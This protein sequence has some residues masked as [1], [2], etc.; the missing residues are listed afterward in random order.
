MLRTN[1]FCSKAE[2]VLVMRWP[3]KVFKDLLPPAPDPPP[4]FEWLG[5][6]FNIDV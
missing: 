5:T 3:P 4:G 2:N 1:D 6:R